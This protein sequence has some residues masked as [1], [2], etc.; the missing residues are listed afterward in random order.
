MSKIVYIDRAGNRLT[1]LDFIFDDTARRS[2]VD[3]RLF[4]AKNFGYF[5]VATSGRHKIRAIITWRPSRTTETAIA[6]LMNFLFDE[7]VLSCVVE[8]YNDNT[9]RWS[10]NIFSFRNSFNSFLAFLNEQA[11]VH[12]EVRR[13]PLSPMVAGKLMKAEPLLEFWRSEGAVLNRGRL[14]RFLSDDLADRFLIFKES[15]DLGV[16]LDELGRGMPAFAYNT[17]LGIINRS[18]D[19]QPDRRYGRACIEAY[20]QAA[21][22]GEPV[23]EAVEAKVDWADYGVMKRSYVRLILPFKYVD[24]QS[25]VLSSTVPLNGNFCG[26]GS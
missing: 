18:F 22:T 9:D 26:L 7:M 24:G 10:I 2:L 15:P 25:R 5:H 13:A 8:T 14:L 21:K 11:G 12:N 3:L 17:Y 6:E 20:R 4:S 16:C 23:V 19:E 1:N